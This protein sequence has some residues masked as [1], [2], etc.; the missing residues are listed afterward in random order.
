MDERTCNIIR[1]C[2]G[3][4]YPD[5]DDR[6]MRVKTYMSEE[7]GTDINAY[8]DESMRI[9]VKNAMYD[10]IDTCDKPSAFLRLIYDCIDPE[11]N[12]TEQICCSFT[13][14]RIKD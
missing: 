7:C 8:S 10:Y 2:K 14:V 3:I 5:I 9:I 12:L 4:L 11:I 13:Y 1:A 6:L